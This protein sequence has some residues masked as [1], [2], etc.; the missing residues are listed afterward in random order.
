MY[1]M[2]KIEYVMLFLK[3]KM[4]KI[5]FYSKSGADKCGYGIYKTPDGEKKV[6]CVDTYDEEKNKKP[7]KH[8]YYWDDAEV[9][10][11]YNENDIKSVYSYNKFDLN[12]LY[13]TCMQN[14][15]LSTDIYKM[16]E[17]E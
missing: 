15:L 1:Q 9:V 2:I 3:N 14:K 6:T 8:N 13:P 7:L 5:L 16:K 10:G 12:T 4:L 11:I 17:T